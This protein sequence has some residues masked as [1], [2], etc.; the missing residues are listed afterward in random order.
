MAVAASA[1]AFSGSGRWSV[2]HVLDWSLGG[3]EWGVA[4][5]VLAGVA[6]AAVVSA[7]G[8]RVHRRGTIVA[9]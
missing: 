2:D 3:E 4:A 7:R 9:G 5:A 8:I 1:M 6:A